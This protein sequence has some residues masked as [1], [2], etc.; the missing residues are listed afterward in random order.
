MFNKNR[1]YRGFV[2]FLTREIPWIISRNINFLQFQRKVF[3]FS[4]RINSYR[5]G[6]GTGNIH[7]NKI[8]PYLKSQK[9][10]GN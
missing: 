1:Y 4:P 5:S 10:D 7:S 9:N 2:W 6:F 3:S 8:N